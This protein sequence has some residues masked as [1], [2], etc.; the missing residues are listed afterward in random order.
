MRFD[1]TQIIKFIVYI[2]LVRAGTKVQHKDAHT[3]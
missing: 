2:L 1:Y 3:T